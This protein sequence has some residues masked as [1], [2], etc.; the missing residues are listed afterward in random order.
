MSKDDV[1][2]DLTRFEYESPT[3]D[4]IFRWIVRMDYYRIPY[5]TDTVTRRFPRFYQA[6]VKLFGDWHNALKR[7]GITIRY[8]NY[9]EWIP[10]DTP[11]H[12]PEEYRK[13]VKPFIAKLRKARSTLSVIQKYTIPV[14]VF[15]DDI[16]IIMFHSRKARQW[17]EGNRVVLQKFFR[18]E[19]SPYQPVPKIGT[20]GYYFMG[21][22]MTVDLQPLRRI[23]CETKQIRLILYDIGTPK[24]K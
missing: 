8:P 9:Y 10:S 16:P 14:P 12:L 13:G 15:H 7:S 2:T 21:G 6:A 20:L 3:E 11:L 24:A 1:I 17:M 19:E 5:G 18:E 4:D 22:Q 23:Q